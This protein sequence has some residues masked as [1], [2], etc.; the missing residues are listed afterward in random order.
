MKKEYFVITL[1]KWICWSYVAGV[2]MANIIGVQEPEFMQKMWLLCGTFFFLSAYLFFANKPLVKYTLFPAFIILGVA[3]YQMRF[4]VSNKD[5]ISNYID[6]GRFDKT[7]IRGTII[8]DPDVRDWVTHILVKPDHIQ[9]E[10][11]EMDKEGD[12]TTIDKR[13]MRPLKGKTGDILVFVSKMI[14]N[15]TEYYD[16]MEYGDRIELY[17]AL[18]RPMERSNPYGF[19]YVKYLENKNVYGSMYIGSARCIRF[20][21]KSDLG[22]LGRFKIFA[23]RLKDRMMLGLK[24]TMPPPASAFVGGVTVGARGGVPEV[25]KYDF[26]ATGVAHVLALSGLHVGFLAFMLIMLSNNFFKSA[27]LFYK[28]PSRLFN[29]EIDLTP[30]TL[31]LVPFF[32]VSLL[33]VFVVV[34]GARPA[35]IRAAM[36]YSI[37]IIF[38]MWIGLNIRRTTSVTIP[39]SAAI[40]LSFNS[41]MIYD[42]S[43]AL[44]F[45]A[46]WAI[47][48]LSDPLR[49]IFSRVLVGWGQLVFFLF[50]I[51][52]MAIL[53]VSPWLFANSKF[54]MLFISALAASSLVAYMLEKKFPLIGFEFEGWWPYLSGFMCVQLAIQIGMMWPLSGIYFN[55]FPVAGLLANFIAIPLIGII[56]PLGLLGEIFTLVPGVGQYIGLSI[57]AANTLFSNFFLW[58]A[59]FFR[60]YF[61]YPIQSAPSAKWLA[62]YYLMV[63]IFGFNKDIRRFLTVRFRF[64]RKN[65]NWAI[66]LLLAFI[67]SSGYWAEPVVRGTVKKK[68]EVLVTFLDVE[69]GNCILI[70]TPLKRNILI[71]AGFRGDKRYWTTGNWGKGKNVVV[72]NLSGYN[73]GRLDK[74]VSTN[75]LPENIG[76]LIYIINYF[77]VKEVWDSLDPVRFKK[78]MNYGEFLENLN[79]VRLEIKKDDDLPIGAYLNYYDFVNSGIY[80]AVLMKKRS[81]KDEILKPK[82]IP[83]YHIYEGTVIYEEEADGK[84]LRLT[85]L[86]PPKDRIKGTESDLYNNSAVLR[87]TYGDRSFLFSSNIWTEAEWDLVSKYGDKLRSDIMVVPDHGSGMAS[88]DR[89]ID[90]VKPAV[91]LVQ[92]GFLEGRG[93][94]DSELERTLDRYKE[95]GISI[96]RTDKTGAVEIRSDGSKINIKTVL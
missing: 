82:L 73:I 71:D 9:E 32:V 39:L 42:A 59:K 94:F 19:D 21:K 89:F 26:Q 70:Q 44:S 92:F 90:A 24:K 28:L 52:T 31:K 54:N 56:V 6:R 84:K 78:D 65:A 41:F 12:L 37:A 18:T 69:Y 25:M 60:V 22:A 72:P 16:D 29:R 2:G 55:R 38:N 74:I 14:R 34:T 68:N 86:N 87:L 53:V 43:F 36:M 88:S 66:V 50:F 62:V 17:G 81:M 35:T 51:L 15:K 61:P 5:H 45:T 49:Q 33:I 75:P 83:H 48:Y 10:A 95:K 79:D 40:M 47:I 57:G 67:Y 23:Y 30:Y 1:I 91:A 64:T 76:G 85:A 93:F 80:P 7:V 77:N 13:S 96:Y 20:L 4:D 8:D 46:V 3:S 27:G 11:P 63:C 58:M